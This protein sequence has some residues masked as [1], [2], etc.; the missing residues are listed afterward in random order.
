MIT[1]IGRRGHGEDQEDLL[2]RSTIC[3]IER[4]RKSKDRRGITK[5]KPSQLGPKK[6]EKVVRGGDKKGK[7]LTFAEKQ[8]FAGQMKTVRTKGREER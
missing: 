3:Q 1:C 4:L 5:R 2:E 8:L 7:G 6:G